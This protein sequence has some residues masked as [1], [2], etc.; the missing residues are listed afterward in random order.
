MKLN[1]CVVACDLNPNYLDYYNLV[2]DMWKLVVDID[3]VLILV[4]ELDVVPDQLKPWKSNII[5]FKPLLGI[6]TAFQ[7]QCVRLLYPCLFKEDEVVIV[8]DMDIIPLSSSYFKDT[9][10]NEDDNKFIVL[11]NVI[12]EYKQ[13]PICYCIASTTTWKSIFKI[14]SMDDIYKTLKMWYIDDYEISSPYSRGWAQDQLMLYEYSS[15][16]INLKTFRDDET[17]FSRLDRGDIVNIM[18]TKD[19]VIDDIKKGVY[20]DFH[21]PRPYSKYSF[22]ISELLSSI[23]DP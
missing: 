16:Y 22:L 13:Y 15:K 12:E 7:A 17:N 14:E 8:S 1:K 3:T 4:T 20:C 11:R 18:N 9:I 5:L 6:P 21:L 10:K 2:Q 19:K 23:H